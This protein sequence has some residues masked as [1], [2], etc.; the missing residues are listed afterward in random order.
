MGRAGLARCRSPSYAG[1]MS[2]AG[3]ARCRSPSYAG[4]M[5]R[6][7][8]ARRGCPSYAGRM[9]HDHL[10]GGPATSYPGRMPRPVSKTGAF[11]SYAGGKPPRPTRHGAPPRSVV[12]E[13]F[14]DELFLHRPPVGVEAGVLEVLLELEVHVVLAAAVLLHRDD[15]PVPEALRLVRVELDVD[16]G[17]DV[18]PVSY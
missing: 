8:L 16:L 13:A 3:L 5:S 4:R 11:D 7:G 6:A 18:V 17:D 10:G 2:R 9:D 12:V 15:D 14:F 1:R